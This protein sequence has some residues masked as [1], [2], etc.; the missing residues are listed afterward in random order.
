MSTIS[1]Y[2]SYNMIY[3]E[4]SIITWLQDTVQYILSINEYTYIFLLLK[5]KTQ[6][7]ILNLLKKKLNTVKV[8]AVL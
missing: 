1:F 8:K 4:V 2:V 7:T 3:K 5:L 6:I